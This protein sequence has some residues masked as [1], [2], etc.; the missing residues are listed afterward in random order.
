[1]ELPT[2]GTANGAAFGEERPDLPELLRQ[3]QRVDTRA[4][5][6]GFDEPRHQVVQ[7]LERGGSLHGRGGEGSHARQASTC[8][9]RDT[10]G[11]WYA[12]RME[13]TTLYLPPELQRAL[14][15]EGRRSGRPQAA[16]IREALAEYLRKRPRPLPRSVGIVAD[17]KLAARGAKE[18]LRG[19]WDGREWIRK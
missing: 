19:E 7:T 9:K 10:Y 3:P 13:K 14:R 5:L 16:L 8:A 6:V 2:G 15:E 12:R 17:G 18:W 11:M 1:M 4:G